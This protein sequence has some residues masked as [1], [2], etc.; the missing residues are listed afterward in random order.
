MKPYGREKK[1]KGGKEWKTDVHPKKG[2]INWWETMCDFLSRGRM[3][4]IWIKGIDDEL[5]SEYV[6]EEEY[7]GK[8]TTIDFGRDLRMLQPWRSYRN[9]EIFTIIRKTKSGLYM[10]RDSKGNEHPIPKRHINYFK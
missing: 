6:G 1:L 4:Q 3:K 7:I 5:K 2:Y 10:V 9:E 8:E